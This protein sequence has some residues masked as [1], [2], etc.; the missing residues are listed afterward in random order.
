VGKKKK[1]VELCCNRRGFTF[2]EKKTEIGDKK[3]KVEKKGEPV[4][5]GLIPFYCG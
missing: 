5:F 2:S 4:T 3:K 1:E